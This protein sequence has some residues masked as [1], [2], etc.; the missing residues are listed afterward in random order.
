[1]PN[2]I[3]QRAACLT[4]AGILIIIA[5]PVFF[6]WSSGIGGGYPG[7]YD[8]DGDDDDDHHH[9]D[10]HADADGDGDDGGDD[11]DDATCHG[12]TEG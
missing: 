10:A 9:A 2:P 5:S 3:Q 8:D 4:L 1:M 12:G 6:A 7:N 11:G